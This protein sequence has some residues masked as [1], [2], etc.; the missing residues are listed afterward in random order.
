MYFGKLNSPC[1]RRATA[2]KAQD[3]TLLC[4]IKFEI[5][6]DV[7]SPFYRRCVIEGGKFG[8]IFEAFRRDNK[9]LRRRRAFEKGTGQKVF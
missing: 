3:V 7:K 2:Y 8:I 1:A 4:R 9:N 5:C 6:D